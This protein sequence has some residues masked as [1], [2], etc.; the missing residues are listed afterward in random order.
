MST[1]EIYV[2]ELI[3]RAKNAHKIISKYSQEKVDEICQKVALGCID[4]SFREQAAQLLYDESGYGKVADKSIK[5]KNKVLGVYAGMKDEKSVG[6]IKEDKEKG[7][8]T[9]AKPM[10]VIAAIIPVT[11]GESTPIVKILWAIKSRNAII[12]SPHHNGVKTAKFIVD[13]II[14]ILKLYN[15]PKDWIQVI[16]EDNIS[17]DTTRELM[18]QSDFI[19]ATGGGNLVKAAYSSGTPAI[20]VG[21]GNATVYID[22]SADLSLVAQNLRLSKSFDNSTS[23]SSESNL[24]VHK[25]VYDKFI[26]QCKK[27]GA[28]IVKDNSVEKRKLVETIWTK[29]N[30]INKNVVA[31]SPN[32]IGKL[33]GIDIPTNVDYI[34]IEELNDS[35]SVVFGEKICPVVTIL[36]IESFEIALEKIKS[37]LE[38][39]GMGH[40]C[41]IYSDNVNHIE[42]LAEEINVSRIMVG[43]PMSMANAGAYFN[44]MPC[45]N[46]LGCG[47]W[48]GNSS[49]QNIVWKDLLNTTTVSVK[50]DNKKNYTVE[51]LFPKDSRYIKG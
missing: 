42:K 47:T 13:Y 38:Y 5:I 3:N 6:I 31:K 45:T 1:P 39:Q 17:R 36:K 4:K 43:Q 25:L 19:V 28:Y 48:G 26:D 27:Q 44:G 29:D 16:D 24:L 15:A 12:I 49:S 40:S 33:A 2:K 32:I 21:A 50:I 46:S 35:V 30:T 23:C 20:G 18:K 7:L 22:E 11:N 41:G 51:E 9:Y 37:I 34:I 14:N 8:V 10:G